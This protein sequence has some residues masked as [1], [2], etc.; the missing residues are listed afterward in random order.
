MGRGHVGITDGM[1]LP[2]VSDLELTE[3][4]D[5]ARSELVEYCSRLVAAPSVS[6]PGDTRAVAEVVRTHLLNADI[7]CDLV[8]RDP[9]KPS[10]LASIEGAAAGPHL[11]MNVHLDTMPAGDEA[12]WS[13]DPWNLTER[14]QRLYGLGMGNMKGAVAAMTLALEL[15]N[16]R[17]HDWAGRITFAAVSDEVM[18]GPD[19]AAWLL[20]SRPDLYGDALICGEGPGWMRLAIG[21]K[22]VAWYELEAEGPS[23]HSSGAH[24]GTS[25]ISRLATVIAELD[26]INGRRSDPPPGLADL[27]SDPEDPGTLLT[28]N[29][30]TFQ[31]G[32]VV[33]QLPVLAQA[34]V[35]AR[36]PPGIEVG[37]VDELV[38]DACA[39]I[40]GVRWHRTKGWNSNWTDPSATIVRC[41]VDAATHV[42][43]ESPNLAVRLPASD[44]SRWRANGTPAVCYGPQPTYSAG[45]DDFANLQ[46]VVDCA[47][48]YA[49]TALRYLQHP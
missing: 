13:V 2:V 12:E 35:D 43:G 14:E 41:L 1:W 39:K 32:T 18:F 36:I 19:G 7:P 46:D 17:A 34:N 38:S 45:V 31:G 20:E 10:V 48:I 3:A 8:M 9:L 37:Q 11:V 22:G 4:V 40:G 24:A 21:E 27:P 23:G 29:V 47:K 26:A 49:L 28:F 6:P 42:L 25:A 15:L 5:A 44:A 16:A 30:G 33:S